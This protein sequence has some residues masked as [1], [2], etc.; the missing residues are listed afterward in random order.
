MIMLIYNLIKNLIMQ[1][2]FDG[3]N[4][5]RLNYL[6][7]TF[8]NLMFIELIVWLHDINSD[9]NVAII[10]IFGLRTSFFNSSSVKVI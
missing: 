8:E 4:S 5:L 3:Y 7:V 1:I 9:D 10:I 6:K 2:M